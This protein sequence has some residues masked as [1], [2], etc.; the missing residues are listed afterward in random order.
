VA[1]GEGRRGREVGGGWVGRCL[2]IGRVHS[3]IGLNRLEGGGSDAFADSCVV[4]D[5]RADLQRLSY[6]GKAI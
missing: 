4:H 1:S 6:A 3:R 5:A 2:R